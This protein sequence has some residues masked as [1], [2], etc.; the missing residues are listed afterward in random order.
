MSQL[1]GG[2]VLAIYKEALNQIELYSPGAKHSFLQGFIK[3][4]HSVF[5]TVDKTELCECPACGQPTTAEVRAF[6]RMWDDALT[7]RERSQA[8]QAAQGTDRA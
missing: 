8:R 7:R 6:C 2:T 3:K 1:C 5:R 4:T